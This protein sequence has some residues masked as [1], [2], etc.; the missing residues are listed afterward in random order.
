MMKAA[1]FASMEKCHVAIADK[2]KAVAANEA[3]GYGGTTAT[4]KMREELEKMKLLVRFHTQV[5]HTIVLVLV[6]SS[7]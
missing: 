2:Q 3:K 5:R 7:C 6:I 1:R 4:V